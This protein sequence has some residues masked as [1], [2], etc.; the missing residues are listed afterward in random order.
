VTAGT[1]TTGVDFTPIP[2]TITFGPK[3]TFKD[4][5]I[6]LTAD[7][8]SEGPETLTLSIFSVSGFGA[9]FGPIL[10]TTIAIVD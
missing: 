5:L 6:P 3:E 9:S 4:I 2:G 10:T 7:G 8:V 1:A